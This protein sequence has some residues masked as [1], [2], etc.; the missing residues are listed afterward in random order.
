VT[1]PFAKLTTALH[2]MPVPK[3]GSMPTNPIA[4]AIGEE[5]SSHYSVLPRVESVSSFAK[6]STTIQKIFDAIASRYDCTNMVISCGYANVWYHHLAQTILRAVRTSSFKEPLSILDLCCG[7]GIASAHVLK[8]L[9]KTTATPPAIT[10][11]DFSEEMLTIAK[12]RLPSSVAFHTAN[13]SSL[14]CEKASFDIVFTSFGY[15]NLVDKERAL[16]EIARVLKQNGRLFVLELTQPHSPFWSAIHGALLRHVIPPIGKILTGH[17]EPYVYLA[18][19]IKSFNLASCMDELSKANLVC[20]S[21]KQFSF[22]SCTLLEV[23]HA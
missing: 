20:L 17:I 1:N 8:A 2:Q 12:K 6:G 13:A 23:A 3:D 21:M 16:M 7:T 9:K 22:G 15:R 14:P 18:S 4:K 19:S 5:I 11:I 10:C